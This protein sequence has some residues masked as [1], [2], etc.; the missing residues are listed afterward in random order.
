MI[1]EAFNNITLVVLPIQNQTIIKINEL[2]P[3]Q[4]Q[5]LKLLKINPIVYS[6]IEQF[7]FSEFHL[8]ET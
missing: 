7:A 1:L 3:V 6:E 4:L 2:K 8:G 5:I